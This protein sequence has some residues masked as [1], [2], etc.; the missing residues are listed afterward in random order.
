MTWFDPRDNYSERLDASF[1]AE[2]LNAFSSAAFIIAGL[3]LLAQ[4]RKGLRPLSA[5]FLTLN[6]L[7]IGLGSFLLIR[8][9][10]RPS[11]CP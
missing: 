9:E 1:W 4:W 10:D 6:V 7:L 3:L 5:L 11:I 8:C 2:P